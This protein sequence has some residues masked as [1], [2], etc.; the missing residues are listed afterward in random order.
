MVF[1]LC[2]FG[3]GLF[4]GHVFLWSDEGRDSGVLGTILEASGMVKFD[5]RSEKRKVFSN[6]Y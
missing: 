6:T 1:W 5:E 2:E 4:V 3:L